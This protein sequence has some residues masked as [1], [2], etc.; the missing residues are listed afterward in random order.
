MMVEWSFF[1]I[2]QKKGSGEQKSEGETSQ[3]EEDEGVAEMKEMLKA[4]QAAQ[5][6]AQA[7]KVHIKVNIWEPFTRLCRQEPPT[8]IQKNNVM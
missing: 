8:Q 3:S 7:A 4:D 2:N 1:S 5:Q 6:A